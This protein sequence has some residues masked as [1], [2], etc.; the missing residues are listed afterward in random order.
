MDGHY[1]PASFG[2][3]FLAWLLDM[4]LFTVISGFVT[5]AVIYGPLIDIVTR[6]ANGVI[7]VEQYT[8]EIMALVSLGKLYPVMLFQYAYVIVYYVL[9]AYY[10]KGA[11]LGKKICGITV[12]DEH[13]QTP[14]FM[15]LFVRDFL[16]K[17][18]VNSFACG[19]LNI[20][21]LIKVLVSEDKLAIHDMVAKTRCVGTEKSI[22]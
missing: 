8:Q 11:T 18:L 12:V 14:S 1:V 15:K 16:I 6:Y 9:I 21:S 3:R 13:D 4:I 5:S 10:L 20:I 2:K 17:Y 19:I 22:F 7:T